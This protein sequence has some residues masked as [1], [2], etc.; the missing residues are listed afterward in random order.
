[1]TTLQWDERR[2]TLRFLIACATMLLGVRQ[3]ACGHETPPADRTQ[4]ASSVFFFAHKILY[5]VE[6]GNGIRVGRIVNAEPVTIDGKLV[7][8]SSI[9]PLPDTPMRFKNCKIVEVHGAQWLN[10]GLFLVFIVHDMRNDVYTYNW[11][12]YR[13]GRWS[14]SAT[15]LKSPTTSPRFRVIHI[16]NDPR[17][18]GDQIRIEFQRGFVEKGG[19]SVR[20]RLYYFHSC[21][22][23]IGLPDS[24]TFYR[25]VGGE[26]RA[27]D[28][29]ALSSEGEE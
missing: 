15:A 8:H 21:P 24:G 4:R 5:R 1:M 25:H 26:L 17:L 19:M 7:L 16:E 27:I 2:L 29:R 3:H 12:T 22:G 9:E 14:Y 28:V 11:A 18:D 6:Y 23:G 13:N 10:N 20:E